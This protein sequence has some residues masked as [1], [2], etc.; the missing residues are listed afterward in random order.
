M[1]GAIYQITFM[2]A[3]NT[4]EAQKIATAL[5][6]RG[7]AACVNVIDSCRSIYKWEGKIVDEGEVLMIAKTKRADFTRVEQTVTDLHSYSVPEVIAV[8]LAAVAD[9]YRGFLKDLLGD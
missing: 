6:E 5:V 7:L 3:A 4:T 2:T 1:G 8:D 9:G